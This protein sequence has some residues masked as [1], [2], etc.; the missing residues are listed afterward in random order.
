MAVFAVARPHRK[1]MSIFQELTPYPR[2][3]DFAV[4]LQITA[5]SAV[6]DFPSGVS[7]YRPRAVSSDKSRTAS[8]VIH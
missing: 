4:R 3:Y 1:G 2:E 7:A 8:A 5:A 6:R